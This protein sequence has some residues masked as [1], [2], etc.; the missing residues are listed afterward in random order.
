VG[1]VGGIAGQ[2]VADHPSRIGID[3]GVVAEMILQSIHDPPPGPGRQQ[4]G[5]ISHVATPALLPVKA[6]FHRRHI[7]AHPLRPTR[8]PVLFA[9][10][11]FIVAEHQ[12]GDCQG[13]RGYQNQSRFSHFVS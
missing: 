12:S 10:V 9:V 2:I 3:L 5:L 1:A 8:T 11:I 7:E 6:I 13:C 4:T